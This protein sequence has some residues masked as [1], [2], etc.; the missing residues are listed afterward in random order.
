[1]KNKYTLTTYIED[2]FTNYKIEYTKK[3][4]NAINVS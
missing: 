3:N 2:I 4:F 1:M